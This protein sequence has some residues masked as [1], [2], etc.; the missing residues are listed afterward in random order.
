MQRTEQVQVTSQTIRSHS[1]AEEQKVRQIGRG[2]CAK[3]GN[4]PSWRAAEY[5]QLDMG[6]GQTS[7]VKIF[8]L[9][10]VHLEWMDEWMDVLHL[11]NRHREAVHL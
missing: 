10:V 2:L 9:N 11:P 7:L 8:N 6:L 4:T 3:C 1:A 5:S